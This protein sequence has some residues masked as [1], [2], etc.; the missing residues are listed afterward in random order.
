MHLHVVAA[1]AE[2]FEGV[3]AAVAGGED[4]DEGLAAELKSAR[5]RADAC[6]GNPPYLLLVLLRFSDRSQ[7]YDGR[8]RSIAH[9]V[10][11]VGHRRLDRLKKGWVAPFCNRLQRCSSDAPFFIRDLWIDSSNHIW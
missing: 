10:I 3:A 2:D 6:L 4:A 1:L 7:P 11:L 9:D 5:R 8:G